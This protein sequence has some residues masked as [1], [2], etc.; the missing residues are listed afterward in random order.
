MSV[1]TGD[2]P[3]SISY[4]TTLQYT[5]PVVA[6]TSDP[7]YIPSEPLLG[8]DPAVA[9]GVAD[10]DHSRIV[11][12]DLTTGQYKAIG[13][14]NIYYPVADAVVYDSADNEIIAQDSHGNL[15]AFSTTTGA[16]LAEYGHGTSWESSGYVL[17]H[18]MSL[19]IS[20]VVGDHLFAVGS[21]GAVIGDFNPATLAPAHETYSGEYGNEISSLST[22]LGTDNGATVYFDTTDPYGTI[23]WAQ[24]PCALWGSASGSCLSDRVTSQA[25]IGTSYYTDYISVT[26]DFG[27]YHW[28]ATW[29][30]TDPQGN[31]AIAVF[32][33]QP[34]AVA[35]HVTSDVSSG[36]TVTIEGMPSPSG[37]VWAHGNP[38]TL[39]SGSPLQA[40]FCSDAACTQKIGSPVGLN[41]T[42]YG[43]SADEWQSTWIAP[44]NSTK[45]AE[46]LYVEVSAVSSTDQVATSPTESFTVEPQQVTPQASGNQ[47]TLTL[48]C[49]GTQ[50]WTHP[51]GPLACQFGDWISAML[52]IPTPE[53]PSGLYD[54]KLSNVTLS[55]NISYSRGWPNLPG[56]W[57]YNSSDPALFHYQT[58]VANLVPQSGAIPTQASLAPPGIIESWAGFPANQPPGTVYDTRNLAANWAATVTYTYEV[59]TVTSV[60]DAPPP[61]GV[62]ANCDVTTAHP[63]VWTTRT[64]YTTKTGSYTETGTAT[65][66]VQ[67]TG[68]DWYIITTPYN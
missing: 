27:P 19:V 49:Y 4:H 33:P 30:N 68:S 52:Q 25:A 58:L 36:G 38:Y 65:A 3:S 48:Q 66:E 26:P 45:S 47:G 35:A 60:C 18:D 2:K 31:P 7:V 1:P 55:G 28:L 32:V 43:S 46:T 50:S 40:Q 12:L 63:G 56:Y 34:F 10:A 62:T 11:L 21:G 6:I 44:V 59:K 17:G 39:S 42:A 37:A 22:V 20:G 14:G 29:T 8:G 53:P 23:V 64:H 15:Y 51:H 24:A 54:A 67:V 9:F 61:T 16:L 13:D 57:G 5:N 41:F